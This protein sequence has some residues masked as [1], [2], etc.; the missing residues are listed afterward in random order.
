MLILG[1][2]VVEP[3]INFPDPL[4]FPLRSFRKNP[5]PS[6]AKRP[7]SFRPGHVIPRPINAADQR[8]KS[9]PNNTAMR[10]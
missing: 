9:E 6:L 2:M 10:K 7:F 5:R 4:F 8:R 3:G 1:V